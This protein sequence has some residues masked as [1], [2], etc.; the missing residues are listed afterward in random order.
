MRCGPCGGSSRL[1]K[2]LAVSQR[3]RAVT[4]TPESEGVIGVTLQYRRLKRAGSSSPYEDV[5]VAKARRL[6]SAVEMAFAQARV[7]FFVRAASIQKLRV[8]APCLM[9]SCIAPDP[10]M[11]TP[12][13]KSSCA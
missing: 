5:G 7:C 4:L 11:V 10:V 12:S 6:G 8:A 3:G 2:F 1:F 13:S 9:I